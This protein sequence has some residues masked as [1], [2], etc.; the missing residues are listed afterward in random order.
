MPRQRIELEKQTLLA[1]QGQGQ[2]VPGAGREKAA[3]PGV[4]SHGSH[5]DSTVDEEQGGVRATCLDADYTGGKS[6]GC[7]GPRHQGSL[8]TARLTTIQ[9]EKSATADTL[10]G[11]EHNKVRNSTPCCG[12]GGI[13]RLPG[14]WVNLGVPFCPSS[15]DNC[16]ACFSSFLNHRLIACPRP[17]DSQLDLLHMIRVNISP[18]F[19]LSTPDC[20]PPKHRVQASPLPPLLSPTVGAGDVVSAKA[21]AIPYDPLCR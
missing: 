4:M 6:K 9:C 17:A 3:L 15:R 16:W 20:L 21:A 1:C 19:A 5:Q 18:T 7:Q 13:G 12:V 8:R 10:P 2:A 14:W 11:A